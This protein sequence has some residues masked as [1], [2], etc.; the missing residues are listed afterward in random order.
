MITLQFQR[1]PFHPIKRTV[2]V[3]WNEII[4]I[5][6]PIVMSAGVTSENDLLNSLTGSSLDSIIPGSISSFGLDHYRL[7]L[8]TRPGSNQSL[9]SLSHLSNMICYDHN[10]ERMRPKIIEHHPVFASNGPVGV[11]TQESAGISESQVLQETLSI[12][13]SSKIKL[14]YRSSSAAGYLSTITLQLTG[15]GPSSSS[16]GRGGGSSS[17]PKSLKLIHVRIIVEGN[18]FSK[19]LEPE[20]D[21]NMTYAWN[22]RNVYRQKVYGMTSAKSENHF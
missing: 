6:S 16:G 4:V 7:M 18:Y 20:T 9:D 15:F 1:S 14:I 5:Q 10:Y 22:K 11:A 12:P 2:M 19:V 3:P 17:V 21:L 13:G 8:K